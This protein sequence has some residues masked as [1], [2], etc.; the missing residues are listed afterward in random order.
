MGNQNLDYVDTHVRIQG[1]R[2]A[3][4]VAYRFMILGTSL[5]KLESSTSFFV[6][7]HIMLYENRCARIA[8][9]MGMLSPPKK[10]KLKRRIQF[11]LQLCRRLRQQLTRMVSRICLSRGMSA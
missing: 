7:P 4:Q 3:K 1:A 2:N 8:W 10:K 9:L 5:K 6:A 11:G